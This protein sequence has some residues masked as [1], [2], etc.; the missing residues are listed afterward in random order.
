MKI[1]RPTNEG[2]IHDDIDYSDEILDTFFARLSFKCMFKAA[3]IPDGGS[4]CEWISTALIMSEDMKG[5]YFSYLNDLRKAMKFETFSFGNKPQEINKDIRMLYAFSLTYGY[6]PSIED[7]MNTDYSDELNHSYC[8]SVF[9]YMYNL[10][11][12]HKDQ[13]NVTFLQCCR[14]VISL[15]PSQVGKYGCMWGQSDFLLWFQCV[16]NISFQFLKISE[17]SQITCFIRMILD[18]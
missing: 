9:G 1:L 7:F 14:N 5:E 13:T 6:Q 17:I 11:K 15:T 10:C 4:C 8:R 2:Y 18:L 12:L 3:D 16:F